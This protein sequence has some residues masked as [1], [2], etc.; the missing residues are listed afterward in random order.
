LGTKG[1]GYEKS[2]I[3]VVGQENV[4]I[5]D[6]LQLRDVAM[7]TIFWLPIYGHTLAPPGEYDLTVRVWRQSG[8]MSN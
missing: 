8:L 3:R 5:A 4:D 6:T 7:A 1:L 2:V